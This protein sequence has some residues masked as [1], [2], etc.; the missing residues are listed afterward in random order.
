MAATPTPCAQYGQL[1]ELAPPP[2][3]RSARTLR[4]K[5]FDQTASEK[6]ARN[7]T[8]RDGITF[9]HGD[10]SFVVRSTTTTAGCRG[11]SWLTLTALRAATGP[12]M[13]G[14]IAAMPR[15]LDRLVPVVSAAKQ[16]REMRC[17]IS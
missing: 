16:K 3:R 8:A 7:S 11:R 6:S 2:Q 5:R 9:W 10:C 17:P 1:L 14:A 12:R 15:T 4:A 13:L